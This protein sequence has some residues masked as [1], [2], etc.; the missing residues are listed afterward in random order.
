MLGWLLMSAS[1][2]WAI[3]DEIRIENPSP[4]LREQWH[5]L[6]DRLVELDPTAGD[7]I[8]EGGRL[9][10]ARQALR[11]VLVRR[12]L[13]PSPQEDARIQR[14]TDR[15]VLGRWLDQAVTAASV[16]EALT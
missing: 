1:G 7:N 16:G 12:N 11:S 8:R 10:Q 6:V 4:E 3:Y 13:L 9:E 14:C 15:A 2:K 5:W